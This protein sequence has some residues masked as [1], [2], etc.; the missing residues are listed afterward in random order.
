MVCLHTACLTQLQNSSLE[1][2]RSLAIISAPLSGYEAFFMSFKFIVSEAQSKGSNL[3]NR[4]LWGMS[5]L[6]KTEKKTMEKES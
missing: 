1:E 2:I 3:W 6:H 4:I 5:E